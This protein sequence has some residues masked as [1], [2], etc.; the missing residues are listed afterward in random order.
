MSRGA[1]SGVDLPPQSSFDANDRRA[2]REIE[3]DDQQLAVL[4]W[5]L[6]HGPVSEELARRRIARGI[7]GLDL[8]VVLSTYRR[9]GLLARSSRAGEAYLDATDAVE[10]L[11]TREA[12]A[13]TEYPPERERAKTDR[14]ARELR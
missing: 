8:E 14:W 2:I 6:D 7:A 1:S 12:S 5:L 3:R 9:L 10:A 11:V 13:G 4:S